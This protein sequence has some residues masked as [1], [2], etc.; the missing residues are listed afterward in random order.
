[1]AG[2][3]H[4]AGQIDVTAAERSCS[5]RE[6]NLSA[7]RFPLRRLPMMQLRPV[8]KIGVRFASVS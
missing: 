6:K 3:V 5:S 2:E 4:Y 7:W 1:M 8:L